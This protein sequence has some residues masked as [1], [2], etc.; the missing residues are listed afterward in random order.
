LTENAT[1]YT[2]CHEFRGESAVRF[3][4]APSLADSSSKLTTAVPKTRL[5]AGLPIVVVLTTEIDTSR[6][7]AGDP[8]SAKIGKAIIDPASKRVLVPAGTTLRGR[9]THMERHLESEK[10]FLVGLAFEKFPMVL[11][12]AHQLRDTRVFSDV[13]GRLRFPGRVYT[14]E[15]HAGFEGGGT[16]VFPAGQPGYVVPSG[17]ES[18]WITIRGN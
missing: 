13:E 7:A 4:E 14:T 2:G 8:V 11:D 9:I 5:P 16:F 18:N 12:A 15:S 17:Y 3:D 6:A 10:Y 1:T